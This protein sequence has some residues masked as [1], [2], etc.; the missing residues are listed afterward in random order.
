M[1]TNLFTI[2]AIILCYIAGIELHAQNTTNLNPV[3]D[4]TY[5]EHRST[6]ESS[7]T[8][9][10]KGGLA[11]T[12]FA[13]ETTTKASSSGIGETEGSFSVSLTGGA[14]YNVPIAVP[15]GIN[16][17]QPSIAIAYNSQAGKGIAGWGWSVSGLSVISRIPSTKY[18]DGVADP[19]DFDNL[20]RFALDGQRL[21]LKSGSYG[22]NGAEYQTEN[23]SNI[24]ITSHGVSPYGAV[25]GPSYF[26]IYYPDGSTAY[27][28][29]SANS[30]SKL[31][32][33][34]SYWE[35]P[36]GL[37]ISYT[38]ETE[39]G[40]IT[41]QKIGYG[42]QGTN[43]PL[44]EIEFVYGSRRQP[45]QSYVGGEYFLRKKLLKEIK[46]I[47]NGTPYRNYYLNH[48]DSGLY[49][50]L[51]SIQEKTGDN[52]LA[53]SPIIFT[54]ENTANSI[55]HTEITSSLGVVN[56]E[57][58]NAEV[59]SLDLTGNGK[60]DFIVSPKEDRNKF[61][62]FKGTNYQRPITVNT[63]FEVAHI[64]PT[65]WLTNENKLSTGQGFTVIEE[66]PSLSFE[67]KV[68]SNAAPSSGGGF[69]P[70]YSKRWQAPTNRIDRDCDAALV[71]RIPQKFISG[72]FNGD[73]LT[74]IIAISEPSAS[75]ECD[76]V[77]NC[78]PIFQNCCDCTEISTNSN[79]VTFI[80]LDRRITGSNF[81]STAGILNFPMSKFD[82]LLTMDVNGD[83]KTDFIHVDRE[84]FFVYTLDKDNKLKLLWQTNNPTINEGLPMLVGDYNGD[85][86]SDILTPTGLNTTK[87]TLF[88]STGNS[89]DAA[90][91]THMLY[92]S[93]TFDEATGELR[94]YTLVP[95]DFNGDGKTD[96]IE[97]RTI[98]NTNSSTGTQ[99]VSTYINRVTDSSTGALPSFPFAGSE[100][101]TGNLKHYPIPIFLSS[102]KRNA[103]LEFASI[104][105]QWISSFGF[106]QDN[107]KNMA[108][109]K[110][111]NNGVEYHMHYAD[112]NAADLDSQG[113]YY[114]GYDQTYP[115]VDIVTSPGTK[116]V[117][118]IERKVAST[119][120]P[121]MMQKFSYKGA[122]SHLDGRGFVGFQYTARSNWHSSSADRIY[123]NFSF[124]L[125]LR[126]AI[127]EQYSTPFT[128][129][130]GNVP[131][132]Y[133][134]KT[135]N[136]YE[137]QLFGNKVFKIKL[138][139]STVQNRIEGTNISRHLVYDEYNNV[140]K[141]TTNYSGHGS[142]IV[143]Y[144]YR[145]SPG[146]PYSIGRLT[147]KK[148]TTTIGGDI[149]GFQETYAYNGALISG[150]KIGNI[151]DEF[152]LE[153]YTYDEFGNLLTNKAIAPRGEGERITKFEY[154]PS[155][156]FIIKS[157]DVEGLE[158]KFEYNPIN[159]NLLKET[160]QFNLTSNYTYDKWN[161]VTKV[162]D[163]LGN[164]TTT[165]YS[166][167]RR[168]YT[169]TVDSDDGNSSSETYDELKRKI[170]ERKKSHGGRW[171]QVTYEYDQYDRIYR[172]SE[173][174]YGGAPTQWNTTEYDFY[175]RVKTQ[176]FYNGRSATYTY[177]QL[178]VTVDDGTTT[179][180]STR[181]AMGNITQVSDPGGTIN[182]TYFGNGN[183]KSSGYGSATQIIEQDGWGRKTKLTDPSAGVYTY[184]YNGFGELTK[185]TNP[186]GTFDYTYH[187]SGRMLQSK[188]SGDN[189]NMTT[190]YIYDGTTNLLTGISANDALNGRAYEYTYGYDSYKRVNLITENTGTAQYEKTII[191]DSF[192]RVIKQGFIAQSA[193]K[194][195]TSSVDLVY[196]QY[197]ALASYAGMSINDRNAREQITNLSIEGGL[198]INNEYNTYGFL[199]KT[200]VQMP[201]A[202]D[203]I[204]E[205]SYSFDVQRG[206]LTSRTHAINSVGYAETYTESFQ[207]DSQD[208]LTTINGP[209]TKTNTYDPYGRITDNTAIGA[210]A[211]QEGS[212]RYQL[213]EMTL[214]ETGAMYYENR[215][216]QQISY[217]AFKKPV[218]I[219]EPKKGRVSFQ[220]GPMM[221]RT[222][223]WYGG[224]DEDKNAR[225]YHKQYSSIIPAEIVHDK[226]ENSHKFV[227]YNGGSAYDA[228]RATVQEY[229][230]D[231]SSKPEGYY[232]QRDYLGSILNVIKLTTDGVADEGELV[233]SRQYGAWG[234]L[235]AFWSKEPKK[236]K[237]HGSLFDRGYT[238]HEHFF[239]VGLI[240]MNGRM[241]DPQLNRFLSPD[242]YI[243]D[244]YNTQSFN[245]YGYVFNNPLRYNDPS[246]ETAQCD[247]G[248]SG[249]W[250]NGD[251]IDDLWDRSGI[252]DWAEGAFSWGP[253]ISDAIE[254]IGDA[255]SKPIREAGR[256]FRRL[257]G[258][259]NSGPK[260]RQF[261]NDY[262]AGDPLM[263]PNPGISSLFTMDTAAWATVAFNVGQLNFASQA[264]QGVTTA[265]T[266]PASLF[267]VDTYLGAV[268]S[269]LEIAFP[270]LRAARTNASIQ[271]AAST[272]DINNVF[273]TLGGIQAEIFTEV[274]SIAPAFR[275]AQVASTAGNSVA[276]GGRLGNAATRG[277][278]AKIAREL[279]KRGYTIEGGGGLLPEEYLKPL[280]GGR[281]GGSYL[282]LTAKHPLYPTLRINT[283][284][285]LKNGITPTARELR[286][287]ARIRK[288][289]G[290]GEHLLLIPK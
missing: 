244:P 35:N 107:R 100:S 209:F 115:Y 143:E 258:G 202:T 277:Q 167:N 157:T 70:Q 199:N 37:S 274:A 255:I 233:E 73:G 19:V 227:F 264:I 266:N 272:G 104:S 197:G 184:E 187:P 90:S 246:G 278:I 284:D 18:H 86:K 74:D 4:Y 123:D 205:N 63:N 125:N 85:G 225:R 191:Y 22:G 194:S 226:T 126:N 68:M 53:H 177:N 98:T 13:S 242:N 140:T 254:D 215:A 280:G 231:V 139:S 183:L 221:N 241:Y 279:E 262:S 29:S 114:R 31:E 128:E 234:T 6:V 1:K 185:E 289:I 203:N 121:T 14:T 273:Y 45:E 159:G 181:D 76:P 168:Q 124:N 89:F 102:D 207:Y 113:V 39:N 170:K 94:G 8:L 41:L 220:Y 51:M 270:Q 97:Y 56:I 10:L 155:G 95:L 118:R 189:V 218:E 127:I 163:Y 193:G 129:R 141:E 2:C 36:L 117:S 145:N 158:K 131:S 69:A 219:H 79:I 135:K 180:T 3:D 67:F 238:G 93:N 285:V 33:A 136:N 50:R 237:G 257:F 83:G 149:F 204:I 173:P 263:H 161:R 235:D 96:I 201:N 28:G 144:S 133:I 212:K 52:T 146:I 80:N 66:T 213:K 106:N 88:L 211:F 239:E 224:L 148:T 252:K 283:V 223:S 120:I 81:A 175:N 110:I 195:S 87:Y 188:I 208:R 130:F 57:Q 134:S 60:M 27:Y 169:V 196:D 137:H 176:N 251:G 247:C 32:Y 256:W 153:S 119:D 182:Y 282:D 240:H 62:V 276:T 132:D 249:W 138:A 217:N 147:G 267:T 105:N 290:P 268:S 174:H 71:E 43:A 61:W 24:K 243:Q 122:V 142:N 222:D 99:Q 44:N 75:R 82:K 25:Y 55:E 275:G 78:N 210:F 72:D 103:S 232:L 172:Q 179:V 20:D 245:R 166:E 152:R 84:K 154:D 48:T 171:I 65:T 116:L 288:Q 23:Y 21:L 200:S 229:Q 58:R 77:P 112:M 286:N 287:A 228:P 156:R 91:R 216:T 30:K 265:V 186:K 248:G 192:G 108:L 198:S 206:N 12:S 236:V 59:I 40:L 54:Y 160:D 42:S 261:H 49:D 253:V 16:G 38:Y 150:K 214:N 26:K 164:S 7:R 151:D 64:F 250:I 190:N 47:G 11:N 17:V 34:I 46:V 260:I 271:Q 230:N 162:T 92:R 178:S 109:K 259:G 101:I 5:E 269:G 281:K 165:N 15:P 111:S 9:P